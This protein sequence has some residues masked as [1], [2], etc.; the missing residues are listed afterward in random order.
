[1]SSTAGPGEYTKVNRSLAG[2]R[3]ALEGEPV[4]FSD[5]EAFRQ[6]VESH[7]GR[8]EETCTKD[9]DYLVSNR[10]VEV[11]G[12]QVLTE[13]AFLGLAWS[14]SLPKPKPLTGT[15][16]VEG[17]GTFEVEDGVL[18]HYAGEGH[19]IEIPRGITEIG[20]GVFAFS[21]YIES[22]VIPKTVKVVRDEAFQNCRWLRSVTVAGGVK[23]GRKAF[24]YCEELRQLKL[25]PGATKLGDRS[26][27]ACHS[28]RQLELP[29][30]ITEIG[31]GAFTDCSDLRQLSLPGSLRRIGANAFMGC[32]WL[33]KV[34]L[35]MGVVE[36]GR[37]AFR[38]SGVDELHLPDSLEIIRAEAF[39]NCHFLTEVTLPG[40]LEVLERDAFASCSGLVKVHAQPIK[41]AAPG[42]FRGCKGLADERGFLI[43]GTTLVSAFLMGVT[44]LEIPEG[45]TRI[46]DYALED[47]DDVE[48]VIVPDSVRSIGKNFFC[49]IRGDGS[50]EH[51]TRMRLPAHIT[52]LEAGNLLAY[53]S[54]LMRLDAPG[55]PLE[56][57]RS[58]RLTVPAA[59][60]YLCRPEDRDPVMAAA[61]KKTA[62]A[63]KK[64][65][66]EYVFREDLVAA[67]AT[68]AAFGVIKKQ[69]F[70]KDFLQPALEANATG[71]VA[72][73]MEWKNKNISPLDEEAMLLRELERDPFN[74]RDMRKLWQAEAVEGGYRLVGYKGREKHV[75][76]PHRIGRKPVVE[77]AFYSPAFGTVAGDWSLYHFRSVAFAG[78]IPRIGHKAF[79][80]CDTLEAVTLAPGT[81]LIGDSAFAKC[82][83]LKSMDIPDTVTRIG[84]GAFCWC[85]SLE[86]VT[87]PVGLKTL[88]QELFSGC[89]RLRE[90]TLPEQVE[91]I[92]KAAFRWCFKLSCLRLPSTLRYIGP[93]AFL[94]CRPL[95]TVRVPEG[96]TEIG[97]EAFAEC[98]QLRQLYLP[99]SLRRLGDQVF[100][101]CGQLT[102]YGPADSFVRTWA[103]EKNLPFVAE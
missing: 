9:T 7:G 60:E 11:P 39:G 5:R 61:L 38:Y 79:Y 35:P 97:D 86:K 41:N 25:L 26:F 62:I 6:L 52:R 90:V 16:T 46:G 13:A 59:V 80:Q 27:E 15:L 83:A 50:C 23:L 92:E 45:V 88:S 102:I 34:E 29:Q 10:P 75:L 89:G 51:L 21:E 58:R 22:L 36:I 96:V 57:L 84:S 4:L 17:M 54:K 77:I 87:L 101:D 19:H 81:E 68:Y 65:I 49:D 1:M 18:V 66:L 30:G 43:V 95:R 53:D 73:L 8:L 94:G 71:C 82:T 20:E 28:L 3:I 70:Q 100:R 40:S 91:V 33:H 31:D 48:T 69:N 78:G 76:M 44:R 24:F 64:R 32:R 2:K 12:V 56:V 93:A 98:Y 37:G 85:K 72:L 67:V 99:A 55:L 74:A 42:A 63:H 14:G 103:A 47:T